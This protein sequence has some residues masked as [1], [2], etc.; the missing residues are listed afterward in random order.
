MG[1]DEYDL[2]YNKL[3]YGYNF[4]Y[5]RNNLQFN[6]R[7]GMFSEIGL[8]SGMYATDWSW[9]PLLADFDNDGLKDLFVSNGI[10]K[11]LND[12]DYINYVSDGALQSKMRNGQLNESDMALIDKFPQTKIP[13]R[14]F[15]NKGNLIFEDINSTV[16]NNK[17]SY[18]NGAVYA[19]FDNDGDLD[20]VVN[21][22][23]Q[24]A[25]LYRN[26]LNDKNPKPFLEIKLKGPQKNI[27]ALGAKIILYVNGGIRTY[28]NYPVRGFLSSMQTPIHIGLDKAKVD[29][30]LLIWPD[31]TCQK[32]PFPAT[33]SF[34]T[35][36]YQENLPHF[37]YENF[38]HD[39]GNGTKSAID[40]T[41]QTGLLY[42]H[43]EDVFQEFNREPLLPH[44]LS[45]EGP[46]LAVGD[47]NADGREDVFIGSSKWKKPVVFLQEKN[48]RF[49]KKE[50][51]DLD[52][53]S[54]YEDVGACFADVNNDGFPDLVV[55]SG[56]NE[57]YGK[58]RYLQ[59]RIYLND[60][61]G[62]L[63][64]MEHAF[65]SVFVNASCIVP[66]D[67]NGDGN[68]DLFIGGRSVPWNYGEIPRSYLLQNDGTGKFLDVTEK[69]AK[70]LSH[71]GFVTSAIWFDIDKNGDKDL[72]SDT[73][74]GRNRGFHESSRNICKKVAH[75]KKRLVE[76]CVAG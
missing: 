25:F 45:T 13:N 16:H 47:I 28:E 71:I 19:D 70:G 23:D 76:F 3:R 61:K 34:L 64:K 1:E 56:G 12:I 68:M 2:F 33:S 17:P 59:P 58:D 4:Q 74:M 52:R 32:I 65:D 73:R 10:S 39:S 7:N 6:R 55:A 72:N 37:N 36:T 63:K 43:E 31:N 15:T 42:R 26:T 27:N 66:C 35:V 75:R 48:G 14:F 20:I 46:A 60:G 18:S 50:Q 44:M 24:P 53:D 5:T 22:I 30:M 9:A 41:S 69:Y 51:P 21:N 57:F 49:I 8:Y 38:S 40:I 11:R 67:F 62:N 29:S 54:T